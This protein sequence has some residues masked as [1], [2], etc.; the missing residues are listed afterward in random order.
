MVGAVGKVAILKKH[1][2]K[3]DEKKCNPYETLRGSR[4]A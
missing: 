4:V 1:G 3:K 2:D